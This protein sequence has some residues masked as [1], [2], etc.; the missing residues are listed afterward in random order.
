M[1]DP[2]QWQLLENG[3]INRHR[4][5]QNNSATAIVDEALAVRSAS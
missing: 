4:N 5:H 1:R 2:F 3:G